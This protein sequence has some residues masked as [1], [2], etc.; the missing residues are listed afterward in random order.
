MEKQFTDQNFNQEVVESSKNKPILV[1]FFA[2]WCGPC[3]IQSPIV[4][5]VAKELGD[6]AIVGKIN[7][8]EAQETAEKYG[9][10][11]IPTIILFKDGE[12][13]ET[14]VGM[15]AKEALLSLVEKYL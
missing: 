11:S 7:I 3:K 2:P 4:D 13:K 10:M 15:Q 9:V 1:D 6:K 12:V 14:L 8:E 5:D